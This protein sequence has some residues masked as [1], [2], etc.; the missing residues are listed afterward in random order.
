MRM[1]AQSIDTKLSLHIQ[2]Y[3]HFSQT[4]WDKLI[5]FHFCPMPFIFNDSFQSA[6]ARANAHTRTHSRFSSLNNAATQRRNESCA[7]ALKVE[8]K[9]SMLKGEKKP[10]SPTDHPIFVGEKLQFLPLVCRIGHGCHYFA[11]SAMCR[12]E[13]EKRITRY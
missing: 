7:P 5:I 13:H 10:T 1:C 6:Y 11:Q 2:R 8:V 9:I 3:F 12:N 4:K